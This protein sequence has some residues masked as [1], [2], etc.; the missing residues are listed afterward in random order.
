[1]N[2]KRETT[3]VGR[4]RRLYLQGLSSGVSLSSADL[5][6]TYSSEKKSPVRISGRPELYQ[7]EEKRER[8]TGKKKG[9]GPLRRKGGLV[10][11]RNTT[12]LHQKGG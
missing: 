7:K 8:K 5:E 2:D 10:G 6:R 4:E 1:V 9:S 3:V 12:N 11:G